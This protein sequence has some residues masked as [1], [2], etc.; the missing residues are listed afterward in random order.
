MGLAGRDAQQ[1]SCGRVSIDCLRNRSQEPYQEAG[2][3]RV[4]GP[5][6]H[7]LPQ[8]T[9]LRQAR[10][11]SHKEKQCFKSSTNP[12]NGSECERQ[13]RNARLSLFRRVITQSLFSRSKQTM[14]RACR[15]PSQDGVPSRALQNKQ[16]LEL[17]VDSG[18][19][20][21]PQRISPPGANNGM[22]TPWVLPL[23]A[24]FVGGSAM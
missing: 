5:C 13:H 20:K 2:L 6:R 15:Q 7:T 10:H 1:A 3:A 24:G 19:Q 22:A 11:R 14:D 18:R 9:P 4:P 12:H 16:R 21:R 17:G 8:S 23:E